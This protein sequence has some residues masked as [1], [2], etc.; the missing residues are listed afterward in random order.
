V[1]WSLQPVNTLEEVLDLGFPNKDFRG[2][3]HGANLF[4]KA[5][6]KT[7]H[8]CDIVLMMS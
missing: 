7:Q 8:L 5:S 2:K 6:E 1:G 4:G 3:R